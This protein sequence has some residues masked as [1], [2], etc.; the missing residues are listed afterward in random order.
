MYVVLEYR[1]SGGTA[2][3][4]GG[5][6]KQLYHVYFLFAGG[7]RMCCAV[8]TMVDGCLAVLENS[9]QLWPRENI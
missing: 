9:M 2:M 6:W 3:C 4:L 1:A 8:Q 5:E 7:W